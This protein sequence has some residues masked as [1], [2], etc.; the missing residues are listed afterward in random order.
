MTEIIQDNIFK[1]RLPLP[2]K[3]DHV[4]CYAIKGRDGWSIVDTGLAKNLN[5]W[6][7]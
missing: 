4:N 1:V 3:L 5:N 2:F 7:S 6:G